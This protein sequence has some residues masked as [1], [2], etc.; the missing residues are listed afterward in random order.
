MQSGKRFTSENML[1]LHHANGFDI[2]RKLSEPFDGSTIVLT[3]PDCT[4]PAYAGL[5]ANFL[6]AC[7]KVAFWY[8]SF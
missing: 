5:K 7:S 8:V 4:P 6:F 1:H 2:R 3:H